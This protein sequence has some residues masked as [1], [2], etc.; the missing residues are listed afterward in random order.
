[1]SF[2]PS[3][4]RKCQ[5]PKNLTKSNWIFFLTHSQMKDYSPSTMLKKPIKSWD[6]FRTKVSQTNGKKKFKK[7]NK[8]SHIFPQR[9]QNH[10]MEITSSLHAHWEARNCF[11]QFV[12]SLWLF[13]RSTHECKLFGTFDRLWGFSNQPSEFKMTKFQSHEIHVRLFFFKKSQKSLFDLGPRCQPKCHRYSRSKQTGKY[14]FI[15]IIIYY[16][17]YYY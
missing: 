3:V 6:F 11:K 13:E 5:I 7:K 17:Y 8:K 10:H 1:M 2:K 14:L 9:Y 12:E 4:Y 16:Y 15:I